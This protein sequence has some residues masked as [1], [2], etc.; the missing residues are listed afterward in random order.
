MRLIIG[1]LF[2]GRKEYAISKYGESITIYSEL[3]DFIKEE[4]KSNN[5]QEEIISNV[6]NIA[7]RYDVVIA[8]ESYGGLTPID[9]E[10]RVF[11]EI[12]GRTLVEL[13]NL[14]MSVERVV[15]G[16]GITLK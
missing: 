13:A 8:E 7:E 15:C 3:A 6:L 10:E 9:Y 14:A 11:T 4:L 12:Y 1:D 16:I 5:T 2:Q